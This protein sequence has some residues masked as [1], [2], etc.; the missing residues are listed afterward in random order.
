MEIL[1]DFTFGPRPPPLNSEASEVTPSCPTL[2]P[3]TDT[4]T[5][6]PDPPAWALLW[7]C[8][9]SE[10]ETRMTQGSLACLRL[11]VCLQ[12]AD[13]QLGTQTWIQMLS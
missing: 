12:G 6:A 5:P 10:Q 7:G 9:L 2:V 3:C 13:L 4:L 8:Q 11:C 1:L